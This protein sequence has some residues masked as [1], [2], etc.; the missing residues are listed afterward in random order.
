MNFLKAEMLKTLISW[1]N[2]RFTPLL[3]WN[4]PPVGLLG[5]NLP[6]DGGKK[7]D[8]INDD[9]SVAMSHCMTNWD[10]REVNKIRLT[11]VS[12]LLAQVAIWPLDAD[13]DDVTPHLKLPPS[14][15]HMSIATNC[16]DIWIHLL[17]FQVFTLFSKVY[18]WLHFDSRSYFLC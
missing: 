17:L 6:G 3:S 10:F 16:P 2:W 8:P 7:T 13:P 1:H 11:S 5:T 15:V 18:F 4:C 14:L 9:Q 12:I